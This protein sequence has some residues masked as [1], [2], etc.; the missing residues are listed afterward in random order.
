VACAECGAG[1]PSLL[2]EHPKHPPCPECGAIALAVYLE[3]SDSVTLRDAVT[4]IVARTTNTAA[5]RRHALAS[6]VDDIQAAAASGTAHDAQRALKSALEA[7]HELS[8]CADRGE[9]AQAA[10]GV[11]ELADWYAHVGARNAAHHT[12]S[13]ITALHILEPLDNRLQWEIE[14]QA[15]ASLRSQRQRREYLARLEG[16]PVL[17]ALRALV[18]RVSATVP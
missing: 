3:V 4:D 7:I 9:W 16:Q 10:W 14:P 1:R 18:A 15:V 12:S 13:T 17:P 11:D 8:D 6:A 2:A 5:T